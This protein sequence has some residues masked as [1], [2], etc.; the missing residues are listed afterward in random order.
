MQ[1]TLHKAWHI[2][3]A[4]EMGHYDVTI[5]AGS[6]LCLSS[7]SKISSGP[8]VP[9][10]LGVT[11][12]PFVCAPFGQGAPAGG[13]VQPGRKWVPIMLVDG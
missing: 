1:S 7:H 3:G 12:C 9:V 11:F 8:M 4:Q 13:T 5:Q 10:T 2:V 6:L